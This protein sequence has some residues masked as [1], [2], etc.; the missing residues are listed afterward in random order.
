MPS[1]LSFYQAECVIYCVHSEYLTATMCSEANILAYMSRSCELH[2]DPEAR[3]PLQDTM[4][5]VCEKQPANKKNHHNADR[6]LEFLS[7]FHFYRTEP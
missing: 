3:A 2:P 5:P 4:A 6:L 1:L 7:I